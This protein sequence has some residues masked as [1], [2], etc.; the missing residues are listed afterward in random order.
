MFLYSVPQ[1][2]LCC[3]KYSNMYSYAGDN[4]LCLCPVFHIFIHLFRKY[5]ETSHSLICL[6]SAPP[7]LFM[8]AESCVSTGV[9]RRPVLVTLSP[10]FLCTGWTIPTLEFSLHAQTHNK[11]CTVINRSTSIYLRQRWIL[12]TRLDRKTHSLVQ[13]RLRKAGETSQS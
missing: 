4:T 13:G 11:P 3:C 6:R 2:L 9:Q 10:V 1:T 5:S 12:N 7:G 8:H